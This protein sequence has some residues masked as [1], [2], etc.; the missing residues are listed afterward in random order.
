MA[1]IN[2][3]LYP[4]DFTEH[5]AKVLPMV[6]EMV[7]KLGANLHTLHV[8]ED[9][10]HYANF[11]VP[12]PSLDKMES[13]LKSGAQRKMDEFVTKHF[14]DFP[15]VTAE[16]VNGD[17]A[18]EVIKYAQAHDIDLI[19]TATHGRKGLE[20]AIFGSVAENVVRNSP[21]PVLTINPY[22]LK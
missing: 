10:G 5:H 2:N 4:V 13:D 17:P 22:K 9:L 20:H 15:S 7:E 14:A 6:K 21:V 8:V 16:V 11:F 18:S 1:Q 19:I 3:I 12:H